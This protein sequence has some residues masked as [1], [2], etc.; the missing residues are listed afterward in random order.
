MKARDVI[1]LGAP[2]AGK[3][4]QAKLLSQELGILHIST[5]DI[6][7]GAVAAGTPLGKAAREYMDRGDLVPDDLMVD[8]VADRLGRE[9]CAAGVLLDGF[10]RTLPQAEALASVLGTMARGEGVALAIDVPDEEL[11]RRLSSRRT[12]R[13]CAGT[14]SLDSL[15]AETSDCPQCGGELY[16]RADD[17]PEAVAQRLRVYAAQTKPLLDYYQERGRLIR[18]NG[19]GTIEEIAGRALAALRTEGAG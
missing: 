7:R 19:V 5:G 15:P 16:Q 1:L 3:G 14:F 12:C 18:V 10:P 4:T 9:D 2:G 11:V 6:L 13:A 17:A 8:L